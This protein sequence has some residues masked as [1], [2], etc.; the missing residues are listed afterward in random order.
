[1]FMFSGPEGSITSVDLS[2]C[3]SQPCVFHHGTNVTVTI[4]FKAGICLEA[5]IGI[6]LHSLSLSPSS[7]P[8]TSKTLQA[9]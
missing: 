8:D 5:E 4:K 1:M 3:T 7:R 9:S 2:P 6:Q